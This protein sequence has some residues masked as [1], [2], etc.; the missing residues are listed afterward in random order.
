MGLRG[1]WS[2]HGQQVCDI[3]RGAWPRPASHARTLPSG[4]RAPEAAFLPGVMPQTRRP[5]KGPG[6][7]WVGK[8]S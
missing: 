2:L 1:G 7:L 4:P 6:L 3:L 5:D 8:A